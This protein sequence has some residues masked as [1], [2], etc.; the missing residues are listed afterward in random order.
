MKSIIER[1]ETFKN[2]SDTGKSNTE[3]SS[4]AVAKEAR[5]NK[6]LNLSY[7][8]TILKVYNLKHIKTLNL[9]PDHCSKFK[10]QSGTTT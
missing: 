4:Q 9:R 6:N 10:V 1:E 5:K 8:Y 7:A 2:N 3:K